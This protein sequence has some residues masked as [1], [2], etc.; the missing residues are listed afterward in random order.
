MIVLSLQQLSVDNK[1]LS[2]LLGALRDDESLWLIR[3]LGDS[4]S[5]FKAIETFVSNEGETN[6]SAF[7]IGHD[8]EFKIFADD[9]PDFGMPFMQVTPSDSI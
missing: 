6:F 8:L 2:E 9:N 3:L 7:C 4:W 5:D 1:V